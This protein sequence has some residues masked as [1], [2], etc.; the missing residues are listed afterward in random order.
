M[1]SCDEYAIKTLRYLGNEL[2]GLELRDLLSHLAACA[3][4]RENLEAEKELSA[5]L[6]RSRPL[7]SAPAALRDQVAAAVIQNSTSSSVH[8]WI[9][10]HEPRTLRERPSGAWQ[11]LASWGVVLAPATVVIALC[12]AVVPNL[13]RRVQAAS[14]VET[15]VATHRNYVNGYL[16]PGLESGSPEEVTAW[17]AGKVPFDFRLPAADSTPGK[18]VVYRLTGATCVNYKGSPAALVK[19]ETQNDK[20]SLLVDSSTSAAVAG[21]DEVRFGTLTFHYYK[22]SVFRV[23]TWTN[24]GLS[25][26][27][28]SS[29]SG[30]ARASCLVCHQNMADS[31]NF[32]DHQ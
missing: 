3:S 23:I 18:N 27:L 24:H 13:E 7:Y 31:N 1:Y 30:P 22:T 17:F 10:Q 29:V 5:T 15:A 25:Y 9:Y 20:I 2:E 19:Y 6:H 11:V 8:D 32:T 12:L 4:C 14:Y 16:Q 28:V 26:A 21:G